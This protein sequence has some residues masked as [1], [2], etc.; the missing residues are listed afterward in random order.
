M[1]KGNYFSEAGNLVGEPIEFHTNDLEFAVLQV[2][3]LTDL[4][5]T[6]M[7]RHFAVLSSGV[8]RMVI[9]EE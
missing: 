6:I 4:K 1:L 8:K 2:E 5:R 3:A 9:G 7:S